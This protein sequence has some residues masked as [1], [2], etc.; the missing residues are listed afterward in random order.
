MALTTNLQSYYKLDS[1]SNDSVGAVNGTDTSITYTT[2]K[3]NNAATSTTG[4]IDLGT[5]NFSITTNMS[6]SLWFYLNNTTNNAMLIQKTNLLAPS[7]DSWYIFAVPGSNN[8][9]TFIGDGSVNYYAN[10]TYTYS[11]S[12]WTHVVFTY[13][14]STGNQKIYVNGTLLNTQPGGPATIN[15]AG[16]QVVML[17]SAT[18][19]PIPLDGKLDEVGIWN[20]ELTGAE[21]TQLYN[22]GA[23]LTYPFTV[24]S[25]ANPAF[26][27]QYLAQQ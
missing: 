1:N 24:S 4:R 16:S 14:G 18:A 3:I 6:I 13:S 23:G 12:T 2:G 9:Q 5:G 25:T 20:R 26:L 15:T 17:N 11:A 8:L 10:T 7:S 21:V 19:A 27:S 22:G